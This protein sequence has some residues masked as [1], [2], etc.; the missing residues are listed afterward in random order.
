[1]AENRNSNQIELHGTTE[2]QSTKEMST[3]KEA[4][5]LGGRDH[6]TSK[7]QPSNPKVKWIRILQTLRL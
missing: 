4:V 7:E 2:L 3:A 5:F 6:P 1:M